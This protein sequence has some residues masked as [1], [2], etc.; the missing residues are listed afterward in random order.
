M[1]VSQQPSASSHSLCAEVTSAAGGRPA[2]LSPP[3]EGPPEPLGTPKPPRGSVSDKQ[4]CSHP[5]KKKQKQRNKQLAS[6]ILTFALKENV[7]N[8]LWTHCGQIPDLHPESIVWKLLQAL[9]SDHQ[10][11]VEE[12]ADEVDNEKAERTEEQGKRQRLVTDL[13]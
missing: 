2:R 4:S 13:V 6:E 10:P 7:L 1:S 5:E 3:P 11:L 9:G 12:T 8:S